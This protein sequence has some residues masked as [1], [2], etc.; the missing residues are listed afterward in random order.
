[1]PAA[2]STTTDI[3]VAVRIAQRRFVRRRTGLAGAPG[4]RRALP[5]RAGAADGRPP[6]VRRAG[7]GCG[8]RLDGRG[9]RAGPVE[10]GGVG[11]GATSAVRGRTIAQNSTSIRHA[12]HRHGGTA[13]AGVPRTR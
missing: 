13:R 7:V 3:V 9:G 11:T 5:V 2:A 1:M 6:R 8:L 12:A 10:R 4:P